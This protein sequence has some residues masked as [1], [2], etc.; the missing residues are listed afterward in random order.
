[1]YIRVNVKKHNIDFEYFSETFGV[2]NSRI[3][4]IYYIYMFIFH[5][6]VPM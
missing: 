3:Y 1:M 2:S 4:I 6:Y 5:V